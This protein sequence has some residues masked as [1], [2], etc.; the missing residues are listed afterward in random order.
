[1][2]DAGEDLVGGFGPD[3]W[4]FASVPAVD[5][6]PDLGGEVAGRGERAAA[7]GLALNNAEPDLDQ[8][9]PRAGG[10]GEVD[11]DPGICGEPGLHFGGLVGGVVVHHQV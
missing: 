1:M 8:V 3:E 9:Q 10:R 7:D 5:E 6:G 11:V 2:V 4:V